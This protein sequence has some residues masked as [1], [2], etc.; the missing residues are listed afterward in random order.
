MI[1]EIK[2]YPDKV[3]KQ[4]AK[5]VGVINV[6]IKKLID[7][8]TETMLAKDGAGLAANQV[9]EL[10]QVAV[11]N[12]VEGAVVL[13]NPKIIK[14]EGRVVAAEGCLSLPGFELEVKRPQKIVVEYYTPSKKD[15]TRLRQKATAGS[16]FSDKIEN[17]EKKRIKASEL[18]ARIICHEVDHLYG[19]TLLDKLPLF[20]RLAAKRKM[21]KT[22]RK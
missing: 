11:V 3:L 7:D 17:F 15:E 1:R 14:R 5:R 12:T 8:M 21:R 16:V 10:K 19:K 2:I 4:K 6:E 22:N 13:L 20:R 18:L 9:G